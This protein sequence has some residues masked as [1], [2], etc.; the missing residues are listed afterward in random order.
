MYQF[1]FHSHKEVEEKY[2]MI[3]CLFPAIFQMM[4]N[5][6]PIPKEIFMKILQRIYPDESEVDI[7]Y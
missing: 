2:S 3:S 7:V 1:V 6:G 4:N 5:G